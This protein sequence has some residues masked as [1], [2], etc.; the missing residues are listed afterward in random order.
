MPKKKREKCKQMQIRPGTIWTNM[1]PEKSC[2]SLGEKPKKM[3]PG[4]KR[5]K[6][7]QNAK[8]AN[9]TRDQLDKHDFG[10]K[11]QNLGK[12]QERKNANCAFAPAFGLAFVFF[13]ALCCC[14]CMFFWAFLVCI[15]LHYMLR[16]FNIAVF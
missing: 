2:K 4:K 13:F 8:N 9:Q 1:I 10:K 12:L 6:C 14:T 16:F 5:E 15:L 3:P 11:M 7:K